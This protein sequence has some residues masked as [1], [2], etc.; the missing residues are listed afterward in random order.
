MSKKKRKKFPPIPPI[1]ERKE[2]LTSKESYAFNSIIRRMRE[3]VLTFTSA[4]ALWAYGA[5]FL[6]RKRRVIQG[7]HPPR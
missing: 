7:Y 3:K 4:Y 6:S 5:T 2:K 1:I